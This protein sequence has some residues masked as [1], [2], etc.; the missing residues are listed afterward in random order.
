MIILNFPFTHQFLEV[1]DDKVFLNLLEYL[2]LFVVA[3]SLS[4]LSFIMKVEN[5]LFLYLI[6][7]FVKS[8]FDG[9]YR[10]IFCPF[11]FALFLIEGRE[12]LKQCSVSEVQI[13][14]LFLLII[15]GFEHILLHGRHKLTLKHVNAFR[16]FVYRFGEPTSDKVVLQRIGY[17]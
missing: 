6:S 5:K 4:V 10:A 12:L 8:D 16:Y 1:L 17:H 14:N 3:F 9:T 2:T 7:N 11:L 15:L 13:C